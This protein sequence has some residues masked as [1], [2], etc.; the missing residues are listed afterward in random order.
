LQCETAKFDLLKKHAM[1]LVE[2][3]D[4]E[5]AAKFLQAAVNIYKQDANWI[6][7]LDKDIIQV[8]DPEKNK[9]FRHGEAIRWILQ[10]DDGK[11]M[12]GGKTLYKKR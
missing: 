8:F 7:P 4:K 2:V 3:N 6:R 11:L 12:A 9:A 5:S 10:S 1:Q